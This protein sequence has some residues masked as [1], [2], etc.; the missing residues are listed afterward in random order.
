MSEAHG[1]SQ[2]A[3]TVPSGGTASLP[4]S[5][6]EWQRLRSEDLQGGKAIILLMGSIFI[7]GLVLYLFVAWWVS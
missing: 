4:F 1:S 6:Q 3:T 7:I 2:H 5:E